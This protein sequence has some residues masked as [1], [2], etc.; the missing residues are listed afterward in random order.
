[1]STNPRETRDRLSE[2]L[3]GIVA[4]RLVPRADGTG[5]ILA[6]ELLTTTSSVR[7]AIKRPEDNPSLRELMERGS[8]PYAMHTFA[9]EIERLVKS[10][11]VDGEVA[12]QLLGN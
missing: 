5:R 11:L 1:M 2:C 7:A 9:M 12:R 10:G 3:Q 8:S 4:Q 6:T